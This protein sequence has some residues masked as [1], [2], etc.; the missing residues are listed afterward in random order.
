MGVWHS[1]SV[2]SEKFRLTENKQ[3]EYPRKKLKAGKKMRISYLLFPSFVVSYKGGRLLSRK[4]MLFAKVIY[5]KT[6]GIYHHGRKKEN[7]H[8]R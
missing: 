6:G 8:G 2:F 1:L 3:G 4:S 5:K 7:F